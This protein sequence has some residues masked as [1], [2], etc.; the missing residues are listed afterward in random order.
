MLDTKYS[1]AVYSNKKQLKFWA[2]RV[3]LKWQRGCLGNTRP[4]TAQTKLF[5]FLQPNNE[6]LTVNQKYHF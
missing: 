3:C 2:G 4:Y 6:E 5:K 1:Q